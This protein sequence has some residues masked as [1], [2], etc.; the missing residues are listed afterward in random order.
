MRRLIVGV[1][2]F[3]T[4]WTTAATSNAAEISLDRE[5]GIVYIN[6]E[7]TLDDIERF[8]AI[9]VT[10]PND[11]MVALAGPGGVALTGLRIGEMIRAKRFTTI[12]AHDTYCASACAVA[13]LG[14][15]RRAIS[16][17]GSIGFHGVFDAKTRQQ[18]VLGNALVA[19]YLTRLGFS[20]QAVIY[21]ISP[22]ADEANWL[23]AADAR[24]IGID[25]DAVGCEK[26]A[27]T[28]TSVRS[29]QSVTVRNPYPD[30]MSL[31]T[32]YAR[33][34]CVLDH[35]TAAAQ[36]HPMA[37]GQL[38]KFTPE[39]QRRLERKGCKCD[40]ITGACGCP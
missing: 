19:S 14:G 11:G 8:R 13:W 23:N 25:A 24:A 28:A 17:H 6:G 38:F 29:G 30:C 15:V 26:G 27:C 10:M 40:H 31:D 20:D 34:T 18:S 33:T 12:V 21:I 7:F 16:I 2:S 35:Q 1:L 22:G 9:A 37:P 39:A 32:Q 4:I 36:G 3:L 5:R